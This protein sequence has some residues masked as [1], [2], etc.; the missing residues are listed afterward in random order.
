M[1]AKQKIKEAEYFLD[2]VTEA[3]TREDLLPNLSAFLSAARSIPEYLLE[4]FNSRLRLNIPL[5][6]RLSIEIFW[7]KANRD[8]NKEALEFIST[9]DLE[10]YALRNAPI[11]KL[12][13]DKRNISIHRSN[14]PVRGQFKRGSHDNVP[15]GDS[16]SIEVRDR[17]GKIK[18]QS[19]PITP[20]VKPRLLTDEEST[21]PD[22]TKWYFDDQHDYDVVITC[23]KF[24]DLVRSFVATLENEFP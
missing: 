13:F 21:P 2:K 22:S 9:Y 7:R 5:S 1:A 11:G 12:L 6:D 18:M 16:V 3:I 23:E 8:Q 20:E 24:L 14:V 19:E 4:E 17:D 15:I 10:L